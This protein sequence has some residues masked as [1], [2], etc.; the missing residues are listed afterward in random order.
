MKK[1]EIIND[2]NYKVNYKELALLANRVVELEEKALKI[3]NKNYFL[4]ETL[5]RLRGIVEALIDYLDVEEVNEWIDNPTYLHL[6]PQIRIT[7]FKKRK[8]K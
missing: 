6:L 7:K 8:K 4:E 5:G 3:N 2:L 1:K